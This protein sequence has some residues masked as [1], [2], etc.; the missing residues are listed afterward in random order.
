MAILSLSVST[1]PE[2]VRAFCC[3]MADMTAFWEIPSF[4][5]R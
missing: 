2:G 3:W 5:R 1:V 4:A